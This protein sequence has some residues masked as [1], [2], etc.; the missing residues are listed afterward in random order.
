MRFMVATASIG[1]LARRRFR[2][3]HDRVGA[4]EN[5]GGDVGDFGAGRHRARDHR[6][7]HL[8]RDHDRLAGAAAQPRHFLLHAGHFFQRH[9][10]AEIAAR[11]HQRVG[12]FED[13]AEPRHGLRFFDLGHHRGA[14]AGDLLRFGDVFRPL[15]EGQRDPVDAGVEGGFEV[16]D[17]LAAPAP[18]PARRCRAGS[19]LCGSTLC[20]RLRPA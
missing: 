6:F 16:G 3:Q 5:G 13:V 20:R 18:P 10:D 9:F 19:R 11:D 15:D 14:A 7:Q 17:V 4:V 12:E 2:R 1:I 8:R